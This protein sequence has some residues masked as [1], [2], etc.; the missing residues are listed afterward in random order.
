MTLKTTSPAFAFTANEVVNEMSEQ[1]RRTYLAGLVDGLAQGRWI[2][3]KPDTAGVQCVYN[4]YYQGGEAVHTTINQWF[5]R[6]LD[7]EANGLLYIL[8]K[9]ECGE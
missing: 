5:S 4:W 3:D 2:K 8:I 1:D 7:T 6:H 9:Q